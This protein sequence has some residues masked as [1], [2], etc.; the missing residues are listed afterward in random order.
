MHTWAF[1]ATL[2]VSQS[3]SVSPTPTATYSTR[4][5]V[6]QPQ[7]V[8]VSNLS[9]LSYLQLPT[10]ATIVDATS[11]IPTPPH[12][13]ES[14]VYSVPAT[15]ITLRLWPGFHIDPAV[16]KDTIYL[17]QR[18]TKYSIEHGYTG[19]L[20][21]AYDPFESD[22]GF[23]A[24]VSLTS[25]CFTFSSKPAP[26]LLLF[27]TLVALLRL[28]GGHARASSWTQ[29]TP[30]RRLTWEDLNNTMQGLWDF[31]VSLQ[32][33]FEV[34]YEVWYETPDTLLI[35]RGSVE[36]AGVSVTAES[37][38]QEPEEGLGIGGWKIDA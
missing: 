22:G 25:V 38:T 9:N 26:V 31:L 3:I 1:F 27:S 28:L 30:V 11:T 29:V 23:G 8:L 7:I 10:D 24:V 17:A 32:H 14:Y 36:A 20:P 15:P 6:T 4:T 19:P 34:N 33:S 2:V 12:P 35:G 13:L 16:L 5:I 21:K 18:F 37:L